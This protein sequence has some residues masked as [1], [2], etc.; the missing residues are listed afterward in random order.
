MTRISNDVQEIEISVIASLTIMFRDP[1][2]VI[3]FIVYLFIT[4]TTL[5]VLAL[6][7][8]PVSGWLISRTSRTL[9]SSSLK[10][11]QYLGRLLSVVEESLTGLR[12][13][14]GFNAQEKMRRQ[15]AVINGDYAKVFKRVTEKHTWPH[16]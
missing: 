5:S 13:I 7:L 12:I 15:F 8:L 14:K 6:I 9:K 4:S 16:H 10:G 1:I 2:T 3:I 11:Q